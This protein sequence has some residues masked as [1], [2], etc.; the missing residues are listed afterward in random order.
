MAALLTPLDQRSAPNP[1]QTG[2]R[3]G[4]SLVESA[5]SAIRHMTDTG[6]APTPA[7]YAQSWLAVGGPVDALALETRPESAP[8]REGSRDTQAGRSANAELIEIVRI[9]CSSLEVLGEGDPWMQQQ[10][11]TVREAVGKGSDR[12]SLV[13]ARVLLEQTHASQRLING[14]RRDALTSLRALL[15]DLLGQASLVGTKSEAF[16]QAISAHLESISQADSIEV[17]ADQ[18]RHL[19]ADA[20]TMQEDGTEAQRRLHDTAVRARDL[21]SE[22][23]RLEAQLAATSEQLLTDHLTQAANRAGLE[24]AFVRARDSL[25]PGDSLSIALLDIDDFKKVNDAMGHFAGDGTLRHL[26][27]LLK[28]MMRA[29]D[30]VARY[31]GEEFVILMPGLD[32]DAAQLL[33]LRAQRALTREVFMHE[34]HRILITFS[35]GVTGVRIEDTLDI[36]L[37]RADTGM[38]QAK[39][40]G[41]NR[42]SLA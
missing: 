25:Q 27:G 15:P 35:A 29:G 16:T 32:L 3:R 33:L 36:A 10:L 7:N 42:V 4:P 1:Q 26:A 28:R 6:L 17:M 5:R 21:E 14:R 40:D 9:L 34:D 12:R 23:Q 41:K 39:R 22:V 13:C 37:L 19:V 24:Q 11:N 38:Y 2:D 18:V 31:G 30:T 20:R 8:R